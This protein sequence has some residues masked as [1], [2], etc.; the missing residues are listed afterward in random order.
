MLC[1]YCNHSFEHT[2]AR[3]FGSP[4]GKHQCPDCGGKSR[5]SLTVGYVALLFFG[6]I[7]LVAVATGVFC[8]LAGR[9]WRE[10]IFHFRYSVVV[11]AVATVPMIFFDKFYEAR[12]RRL[13]RIGAEKGSR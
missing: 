11:F 6:Y 5:F 10:I 13:R 9:T 4:F 2:W 7:A 8:L 3:Y 1:P 12:F